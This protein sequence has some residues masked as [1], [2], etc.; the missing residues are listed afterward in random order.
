[1]VN[2]YLF[3]RGARRDLSKE[4]KN[5]FNEM[6]SSVEDSLNNRFIEYKQN[7]LNKMSLL[8]TANQNPEWVVI[9]RFWLETLRRCPVNSS[10][11]RRIQVMANLWAFLNS[12]VIRASV[13][14]YRS[15]N[16][17]PLKCRCTPRFWRLL[18]TWQWV[19][20]HRTCAGHIYKEI[21]PDNIVWWRPLPTQT[22]EKD[23]SQC[24]ILIISIF[25]VSRN[26]VC[27]T[28]AK[29]SK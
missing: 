20:T 23:Y 8:T 21:F 26:L 2:F 24:S 27:H 5:S 10:V 6:H 28:R 11:M 7:W 1:M 13:F 22:K 9:W 18:H 19:T 4:K 3:R 17:E 12:S 14:S 16:Y 29:G 25:S 15:G